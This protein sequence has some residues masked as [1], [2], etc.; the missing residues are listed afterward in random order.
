LPLPLLARELPT[1]R[2]MDKLEKNKAIRKLEKAESAFWKAES[3]VSALADIIQPFFE[4]E[5]QVCMSSDGAT[6]TDD[7]GEKGFVRDFLNAL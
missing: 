1:T 7:S 3:N 5:I 4:Q 6:I 2:D